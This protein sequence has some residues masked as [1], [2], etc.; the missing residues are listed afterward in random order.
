MART[1][2]HVGSAAPPGAWSQRLAVLPNPRGAVL[3]ISTS[4]MVSL[5]PGLGPKVC[6]EWE[7]DSGLF[8]LPGVPL[9]V[10]KDALGAGLPLGTAGV[11]LGVPGC[12]SPWKQVLRV[13]A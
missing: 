10:N 1:V 3:I 6:G 13:V 12:G 11:R 2:G 4:H 5:S 8:P 9:K 7:S